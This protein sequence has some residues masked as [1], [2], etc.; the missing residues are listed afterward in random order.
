M[1]LVSGIL[2]DSIIIGKKKCRIAGVFSTRIEELG[3]YGVSHPFLIGSNYKGHFNDEFRI[4]SATIAA[5]CVLKMRLTK[6]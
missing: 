3:F 2:S 5:Y 6:G 4:C 1:R